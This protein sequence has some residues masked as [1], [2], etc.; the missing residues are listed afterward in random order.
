MNLFKFLHFAKPWFKSEFQVPKMDILKTLGNS[1]FVTW[2][3]E[4]QLFIFVYYNLTLY[5][6]ILYYNYII[7]YIIVYYIIICFLLLSSGQKQNKYLLNNFHLENNNTEIYA[8]YNNI[9][10]FLQ[11]RNLLW[12][13]NKCY[14]WQMIL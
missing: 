1:N 10:P 13:F 6:I 11:N 4:N 2:I 3:L 8:V 7:Y 5:Y 14:C 12:R 9:L